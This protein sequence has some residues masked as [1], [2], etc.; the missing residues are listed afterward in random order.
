MS[1]DPIRSIVWLPADT[2]SGND[3]NPNFV[4][5][6]ELRLIE[7]SILQTGWVQPI[8]VTPEHVIIDGYHRWMLAKT[9]ERLQKRDGGLVPCAVLHC[10]RAEGIL[11]TVRMNR[12]KGSHAAVRMADLVKELIDVH[13]YDPA[14]IC[15]EIGASDV[16]VNLL[17]QDSIFHAKGLKDYRFSRAWYPEEGKRGHGHLSD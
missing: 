1:E 16:E 10:T 6:P 5:D 14:Q 15:L 8:L 3:Y 13:H 11:L 17:Y 2:L 9:S 4:M 7:R 12:A